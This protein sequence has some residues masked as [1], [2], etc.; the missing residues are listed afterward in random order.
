M[1]RITVKEFEVVV[2]DFTQKTIHIDRDLIC[3]HL[4]T[5]YMEEIGEAKE[6][7][8]KKGFA[9][10]GFVDCIDLKRYRCYISWRT[11]HFPVE[12]TFFQVTF[13]SRNGRES[14]FT[15]TLAEFL[16]FY[17]NPAGIFRLEQL[18]FQLQ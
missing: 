4:M 2:E 7:L 13:Y 17:D 14:S 5:A 6:I 1:K 11:E 3:K 9:S 8:V 18:S 12:R 16:H 10:S 15:K